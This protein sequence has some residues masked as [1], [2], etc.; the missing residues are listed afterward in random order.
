MAFPTSRGVI[1]RQ[2]VL[3]PLVEAVPL[4][5]HKQL[6]IYCKVYV[7]T[8]LGETAVQIRSVSMTERQQS[9]QTVTDTLLPIH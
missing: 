4:Q 7:I 1:A 2:S 6:M 5:V 8:G 9:T 3:P